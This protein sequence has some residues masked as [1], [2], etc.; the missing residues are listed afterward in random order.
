MELSIE[1]RLYS[2]LMKKRPGCSKLSYQGLHIGCNCRGAAIAVCS[3]AHERS[4][5][6]SGAFRPAKEIDMCSFPPDERLAQ[7]H[8]ALLSPT[9]PVALATALRPGSG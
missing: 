1:P 5:P 8:R 4:A 7:E 3:G 9:D 6:N 2:T